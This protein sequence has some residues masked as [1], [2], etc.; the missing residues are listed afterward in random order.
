MKYLLFASLIMVTSKPNIEPMY[1]EGELFGVV[2]RDGV[3]HYEEDGQIVYYITAKT[4][5][6][7]SEIKL[8]K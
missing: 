1:Y 2:L 3:R 6:K 4:A 5:H 7:L 8:T